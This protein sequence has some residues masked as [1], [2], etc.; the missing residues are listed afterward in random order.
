MDLRGIIQAKNSD[1]GF[2]VDW[3]T[4]LTL[5]FFNRTVGLV[6]LELVGI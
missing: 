1:L 5:V 6:H 3:F 2:A 4:A